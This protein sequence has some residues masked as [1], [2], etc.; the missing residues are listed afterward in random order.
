MDQIEHKKSDKKNNAVLLIIFLQL[1]VIAGIAGLAWCLN[2]KGIETS[3][4]L[5]NIN[6]SIARLENRVADHIE[7]PN[8][9]QIIS[10]FGLYSIE[11]PDG[12]GE[13][14][15]TTDS[16]LILIKG[17]KQPIKSAGVAPV[18]KDIPG[19]GLVEPYVLAIQFYGNAIEPEDATV[20]S[21][22]IG[23][24]SEKITGKKYVYK[25]TADSNGRVKGDT[26]YQYRLP[27]KNGDSDG[28]LIISY[29]VYNSDP[30]DQVNIVDD[31]VRSINLRR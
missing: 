1:V 6:Q 23:K 10:G 20:S 31:I 5:Q 13:I 19:D 16:D 27:V 14:L 25:Y 11:F 17:D 3:Q 9:N 24:G 21:F 29:R 12:W 4:N 2:Q 30:T 26:D 8:P 7:N 28:E 18:I 22:T 15:R